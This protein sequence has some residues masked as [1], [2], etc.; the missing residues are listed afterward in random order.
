MIEPGMYIRNDGS[1]PI[2]VLRTIREGIIG[3]SWYCEVSLFRDEEWS[4]VFE[5]YFASRSWRRVL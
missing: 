5:M 1:E 2:I 3:G 4:P